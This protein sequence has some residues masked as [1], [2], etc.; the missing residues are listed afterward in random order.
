MVSNLSY[1]QVLKHVY[2]KH[3]FW[4]TVKPFS[5]GPVLWSLGWNFN[6]HLLPKMPLTLITRTSILIVQWKEKDKL[7]F[8]FLSTDI[9][10]VVWDAHACSVLDPARKYAASSEFYQQRLLGYYEIMG[11]R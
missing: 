3:H 2:P 10:A 6:E 8:P 1:K 4:Q 11:P 5:I 9:H 7:E